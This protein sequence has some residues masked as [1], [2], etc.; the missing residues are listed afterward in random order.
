MVPSSSR[1]ALLLMTMCLT[2]RPETILAQGLPTEPAEEFLVNEDVNIATSL[3]TREYSLRKTGVIDYRTA[4]QI[5]ESRH[6]DYGT[7][8]SMRRR[9][10][11]FIGMTKRERAPSPC[12]STPKDKA[13]CAIS[14]PISR[15]RAMSGPAGL[16][17][18][19]VRKQI[20]TSIQP[21]LLFQLP[22]KVLFGEVLEVLIREGIQFVLEAVGQHPLDFLL[23]GRFLKPFVVDQFLRA[24]DVLSFSLIF[25]LPAIHTARID[26]GE[27]MNLA[28]G[29]AMR[30]LS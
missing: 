30:W 7:R 2:C 28:F 15:W 24:G 16:V 8:W 3:Y 12:G 29:I 10:L 13:A 1:I 19:R 14:F 25:T 21:I 11:C 5:I 22:R 17:D 20:V 9:I 27:P 23:P 4:R 6:N 26:A 18:Q